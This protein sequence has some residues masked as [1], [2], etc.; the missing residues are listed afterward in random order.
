MVAQLKE[1]RVS[2]Q[3]LSGDEAA[4]AQFEARSLMMQAYQAT[5]VGK[6]ESVSN[7][8]LDWLRGSGTQKLLVFAHHTEVLDT[9]EA[10]VSKH[11]KG[12]GHIRIDGSV[13]S[14]ERA[15]R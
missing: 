2:V 12:I 14:V 3:S 11:L 13:Q 4:S 15:A 1:K 6:A 9:I 5:G 10:A 8:V 7:Y